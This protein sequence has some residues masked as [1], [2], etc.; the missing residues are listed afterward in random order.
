M[1][2]TINKLTAIDPATKACPFSGQFYS[3]PKLDG[4]ALFIQND[5]HGH[6][7]AYT[8][9]ADTFLTAELTAYSWFRDILRA[10]TNEPICLAGELYVDDGVSNSSNVITALKARNPKL[11]WRCFGCPSMGPQTYV[12]ELQALCKR[13]GIDLVEMTP[14]TPADW[15][16]GIIP[17]TLAPGVEGL[18]F[19]QMQFGK[20]YK[21]KPKKTLSL[22]C[23]GILP[24]EGK[25][26]GRIGSLSLS[27]MING[28][29]EFVVSVGT[30][31][32]DHQRNMPESNYMWKVVEVEY[33]TA[34]V[35]GLRF[36]RFTRMRPDK[37]SEAC[38]LS[39]EPALRERIMKRK[40]A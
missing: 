27:A 37:P 15:G 3:S 18:V 22:V 9:T 35:G 29:W 19:R 33:D 10:I 1:L 14:H 4:F 21:W 38:N 20:M 36:P 26:R 13:L 5:V 24:G 16:P 17:A 25:H 40:R 6:K 28:R 32:S 11:A 12:S 31:L 34:S 30:G 7:S 23:T 39:E 8:R 2:Y